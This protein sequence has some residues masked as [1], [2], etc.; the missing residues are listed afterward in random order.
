MELII[1]RTLVF[2]LLVIIA[3]FIGRAWFKRQV[4]AGEICPMCGGT[5]FYRTHRTIIDRIIGVGLPARRY[6]CGNP[7]CSWQGLH[8]RLHISHPHP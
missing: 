5:T 7:L 3:W 8:T 4:V 2:F 1:L 6:H